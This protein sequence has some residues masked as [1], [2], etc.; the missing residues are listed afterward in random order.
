MDKEQ[1]KKIPLENYLM[2][3]QEV[4]GIGKVYPIKI[5]DYEDFRELFNKYMLYSIKSINRLRK[6]ERLPK[7]EIKTLFD[8]LIEI[9]KN[10]ESKKLEEE[11]ERFKNIPREMLE[12]SLQEA[13]DKEEI[14][15]YYDMAQKIKVVPDLENICKIFEMTIK[16]TVKY[17]KYANVFFIYDKKG[18]KIGTIDSNNFDKYREKVME[19]NVIFEP[20]VMPSKK[21]QEIIDKELSRGGNECDIEAIMSLVSIHTGKN[22]ANYTY[23]RLIADFNCIVR[24]ISYSEISNYNANGC[25]DKSGNPLSVPSLVENL[26]ILNN[27]YDKLL[28]KSKETELDKTLASR[29]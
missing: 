2:L 17:N 9:I 29:K 25:T 28:K 22:I 21:G 5:L 23:Y 14:M 3:P 13:E 4:E 15:N 26:G 1:K 18:N 27:P 20:K 6:Q 7:L 19:Q 11:I 24:E 12:I 10:G 16:K 8:Y